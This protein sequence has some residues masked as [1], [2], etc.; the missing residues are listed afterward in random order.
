MRSRLP[1]VLLLLLSVF[2]LGPAPGDV[3]PPGD[4]HPPATAGPQVWWS[5]PSEHATQDEALPRLHPA[6]G[7]PTLPMWLAVLPS[8]ARPGSP[9]RLFEAAAEPPAAAPQPAARRA[10]AR[11]PPSTT[12]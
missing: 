5:G 1:A 2:L 9:P 12:R 7:A 8:T 6:P 3:H 10:A 4:L 11:A